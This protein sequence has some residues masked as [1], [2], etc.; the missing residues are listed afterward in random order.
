MAPPSETTATVTRLLK[1]VQGGNRAVLGELFDLVY[2]ELRVRARQQR[3]R[4]HRDYTLNTTALVHEAYL[5]LVDQT[6]A[7]WEGRAHFFAVAA[8]AMRHILVDYARRRRAEKRGGDVQK[9]SLEEMK[10]SGD[11][12]VLT[13]ERAEALLA[14]D[15][16][17][18][19]LEQQS[20][21]EVQV[22]VCRFFG[23]MTVEETAV[24]LEISART[25]K[26]DWALA[27]AWL[28]REIHEELE[29]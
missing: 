24:A 21:R 23:E 28:R 13:E 18:K 12:V 15:K 4:W 1:E 25:V 10:L 17:L 3:A 16:A 7:E 6:E 22:V 26:R 14:L 5:K 8:K 29:R 19:R 27:Q 2:E 11:V 9:L 20:E